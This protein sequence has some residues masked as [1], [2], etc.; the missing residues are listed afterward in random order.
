MSDR[1]GFWRHRKESQQPQRPASDLQ[2][3][4]YGLLGAVIGGTVTAVATIVV[5]VL[6][7]HSSQQQSVSDFLRMQRQTAYVDFLADAKIL[8]GLQATYLKDEPAAQRAQINSA[9]VKVDNDFNV[10]ALV[11]T[12][13]PISL[14]GGVDANA[15][16]LVRQENISADENVELNHP[17]ATLDDVFK[18]LQNDLNKVGNPMRKDIVGSYQSKYG[19]YTP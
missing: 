7:I 5:A 3:A 11:G 18:T 16:Y 10:I 2:A 6:S 14:A 8:T 15:D 17:P 9:T 4:K 1:S 12:Q 13:D 19:N